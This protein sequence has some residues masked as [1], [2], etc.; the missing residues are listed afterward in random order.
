VPKKPKSKLEEPLREGK[1][2]ETPD[3]QEPSDL[4]FIGD[5]A[6]LMPNDGEAFTENEDEEAKQEL[7]EDKSMFQG[8]PALIQAVFDWMQAE[9]D[10]CDSIVAAK[11]LAKAEGVPLESAIEAMNLVRKIFQIKRVS[12]Q[13]IYDTLKKG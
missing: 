4:E 6:T 1:I 9:E 8:D 7:D 10:D 2:V 13:D 3:T 11:A 5:D 12:F